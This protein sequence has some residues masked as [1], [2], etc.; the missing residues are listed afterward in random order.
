[1][2]HRPARERQQ[3]RAKRRLRGVVISSLAMVLAAMVLV[4]VTMEREA[5]AAFSGTPGAIAFVSERDGFA[6]FN[7]YRMNA[8]GFGQT[9]LTDLPGPSFSP[10][11]S[12]DGSKI[13]YRH[14][15]DLGVQNDV[16]Q[17]NADGSNETPIVEAASDDN[18]P[19]YSPNSN[20]FAFVGK[21]NGDQFDIYLMTRGPDGQTSG[22]TR[23][24]TSDA[25]D[26][27]P[28]ISPDGK[29]IAFRSN[30][31]GDSDIYLMRLAPEGPRNVPVKL[32]KNTRPDPEGPP[33]MNDFSPD[34]SP[35]GTQIAFAS[36]RSGDFEVYRMKASPEGRLNKPVNLSRN[37]V[38]S[39][40]DPA[41]SPDGKKIAFSTNRD[42][43][44]EVYR[45]RAT[46]G[47]GQTN[48]TNNPALDFHPAW[49]PLP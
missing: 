49:Q 2:F 16:Y 18:N 21:R 31:D 38:A 33:Y 48:L 8:D 28:A 14:A 20:K 24:T 37:A 10:S 43:N 30:R 32:T 45:M 25:D 13:A 46:D 39:D 7:V 19:V 44:W 27:D 22:L 26:S 40:Q 34:F 6:T 5:K 35:D 3:R 4:P 47:S 42:N 15:S 12:A 17:M 23:L 11:W 9:R 29:R 1:M 36:D 41:W